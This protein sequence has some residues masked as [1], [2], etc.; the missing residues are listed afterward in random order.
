MAQTQ[1]EKLDVPYCTEFSDGFGKGKIVKI[2]GS[3]LKD[4]KSFAV[5]FLCGKEEK[6][7]NALLVLVKLDGSS[8][9]VLNSFLNKNFG[10]EEKHSK[11]PFAK[12]QEFQLDFIFEEEAC[13]VVVNE[14][15]TFQ[16]KYR[17]PAEKIRF[18]QVEGNVELEF[19]R[20]QDEKDNQPEDKNQSAGMLHCYRPCVPYPC[21]RP[22]P[23]CVTWYGCC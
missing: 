12:G 6:A 2:R 20:L 7:D 16:H 5:S 17:I 14:E 11:L 13:K 23:P 8:E 9:M 22:C 10:K 1:K 18:L 3:V 4:G 19:V 21:C 15:E